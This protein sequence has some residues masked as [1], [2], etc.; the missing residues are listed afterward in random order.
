MIFRSDRRDG[1]IQ[2][3]G[4]KWSCLKYTLNTFKLNWEENI[5]DFYVDSIAFKIKMLINVTLF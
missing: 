5:S 2:L 1:G 4:G 3:F